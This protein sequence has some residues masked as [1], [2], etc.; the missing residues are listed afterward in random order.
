MSLFI[1][2]PCLQIIYSK[3]SSQM[4]DPFV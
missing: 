4:N 3:A 1:G 2:C